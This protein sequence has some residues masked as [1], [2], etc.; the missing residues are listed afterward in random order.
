MSDPANRSSVSLNGAAT[1][2]A[3]IARYQAGAF[4]EAA[5]LFAAFRVG[6]PEAPTPMRLQGLALSRAGRVAEGLALLERAREAAP[7]DPLAQLHYGVG[8]QAARRFAE[9]A[10][11]FEGCRATLPRSVAPLVNLSGARL[12]LNETDAALEAAIAAV[13]AGPTEAAAHYALGLALMATQ[14]F[15]EARAAFEATLKIT[16]N[17][18]EGWISL[19]LACYR[20]GYAQL[21]W[22]HTRKALAIQPHHPIAEANFAVFLGVAGEQPE[23]INRLRAVL[24]REPACVPARVNLASQLLS[25]REPVEALEVL[26]GEPP[27]GPLGVHWRAQKAGALIDI[28]RFDEGRAELD[29]LIGPLG[30]AEILVLW[31]RVLLAVRDGDF[32]QS[33]L[34]VA[35]VETL[36]GEETSALLEHRIIACFDLAR[37]RDQRGE[38]ARAF[39]CWRRGHALLSR[40]QPFSRQNHEAFFAA[41]R[42]A[43]SA[44]RVQEGARADNDDSAPV[45]IVGLPRSGTTLTEQILAAHP[46]VHGAGER[47][48]LH[49]TLRRLAGPAQEA[50]SVHKA[51]DLSAEILDET[52]R[53]Y[54]KDLHALSPGARY[55]ID[56]MPGNA[57]HLGFLSTLLPS[58]KILLC[59][60]DPRDVG[61]SIFQHRFFGYH[62]YAHDLGDLG[63]YIGQHH[64]L[65][66]HWREVLP[67]PLLSVALKDW[68][69]DFPGTLA[70]VLAFLDLPH[71]SACERFYELD[72]KVRTASVDQVRRP[73]NRRGIGR[74]RRHAADLEP[75][76]AEFD[77][78]GL[79]PG[80][81]QAEAR[82][83][84]YR[85]RR[86]FR[87]TEALRVLANARV[88]WPQDAI[89][90]EDTALAHLERGDHV[91]A[92][93][94]AEEAV[95]REPEDPG[96]HTTLCNV[97]AYCPEV[98]GAQLGSS[99]RRCGALWPRDRGVNVWPAVGGATVHVGLLGS[100]HANPVTALTEAGFTALD[101]KAFR[102]A[103]FS[104]ETVEDAT[105]AR[106]RLLGALHEVGG[107][108]DEALA[109][110]IRAEAVD[111]LFDLSGYLQA[112][113]IGLLARR[114]APVQIKWAGGQY[115]TTGIAEID[116]MIS[117]AHETPPELAPQYG[118]RLLI[119][120]NGYACWT[121]PAAAPEPGELPF[122][123][124][125][126]VTF[127]SFNSMM[128]ITASTLAAWSSILAKVTN[129][130][131]LLAAPTAGDPAVAAQL[132]AAFAAQGVEATRLDIRGPMPQ[133]D[134]LA[135]YR[136]TDIALSPFPYNAG[137]TL[138]E[139][140]WMGVPAVALIGETFASRHAASHL[141]A[142][143]LDAWATRLVTDYVARAVEAAANPGPLAALRAR[144][145]ATLL[146]SPFLDAQAFG[147]AFGLKIEHA[148]NEVRG[149][150]LR[151]I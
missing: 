2:D 130:R 33:E 118:E 9:A 114:L 58:A 133:P 29:S 73:V 70:R 77:A 75:L 87:P 69:E 98:T 3:A 47:S 19:G 108:G 7:G 27:T 54:L 83:R 84:V 65:M 11:I 129:A 50:A 86:R 26:S 82:D 148:L 91:A 116:Y 131:L 4:E 64:A 135:L 126:F 18:A 150:R 122:L 113:R 115:H 92:R 15:A 121:P 8:L 79:R 105:K 40:V 16:P 23:G 132:R 39:D 68:V 146:A 128:K 24:S 119:M 143:G 139:G 125:G 142:V 55:V 110:R 1:M 74:W 10:S 71:D 90:M 25:D 111:V 94:A 66:A 80:D 12:E 88:H 72:R 37:Y 32:T 103:C 51:A 14:R 43:Y 67:R 22:R 99:L 28:G 61:L 97:L 63:W 124:N 89:L 147:R 137:V 20:L 17:F 78:A 127:G 45:F 5:A 96:L 112:G 102:I 138:L 145:R 123:R 46:A 35:R 93:A 141:A 42:D 117:D 31:R 56:K 38:T 44:K 53:E 6:A 76:F 95:A 48:D 13:D 107:L 100:F 30:D 41:A 136:E 60:R 59:E 140:L 21:A 149:E 109:Q 62:P 34:C 151:Q 81:S 120:P 36:V 85:L 106:Y 49:N 134:M 57:L 52:A 104:L 101:R 144:L